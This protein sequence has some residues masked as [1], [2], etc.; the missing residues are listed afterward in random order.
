VCDL[1]GI[2]CEF[3]GRYYGQWDGGKLMTAVHQW[4]KQTTKPLIFVYSYNDPWTGGAITDEAADPSRH[5]WKVINKI[6]THSP[7][8]LDEKNCDKEASQTIQNA[9]KT[10]LGI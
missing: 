7:Q 1:V 8:F 4:A 10:V 6:G 9:I 2:N 3:S 5:V